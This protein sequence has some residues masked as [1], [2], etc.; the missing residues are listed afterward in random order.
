MASAEKA[1]SRPAGRPRGRVRI[2]RLG[3]EGAVID[4]LDIRAYLAVSQEKVVQG[5]V[6]RKS[7]FLDGVYR[8]SAACVPEVHR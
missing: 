4:M 1:A 7:Y 5:P 2:R 6:G 8:N 3:A